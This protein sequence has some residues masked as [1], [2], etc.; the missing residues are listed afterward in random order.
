M[1]DE[2]IRDACWEWASP[3][4]T[5]EG[6]ERFSGRVAEAPEEFWESVRQFISEAPDVPNARLFGGALA[7]LIELGGKWPERVAEG[8]RHDARLAATLEDALMDDGKTY[9]LLGRQALVD[10]WVRYQSGESPWD[11]WASE[12]LVG[13][14]WLN[15]DDERWAL[16]LEL[17]DAA[18]DDDVIAMVGVGPVEDFLSRDWRSAIERIERD[19]PRHAKLR[20][21]LWSIWQLGGVPSSVIERVHRAANQPPGTPHRF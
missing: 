7:A 10:A 9:R 3:P 18:P 11:S 6:W 14:S 12:M 16:I 17:A 19:A 15:D 8:A 1:A 20:H 4:Q 2:R 5:D 21:A 13:D